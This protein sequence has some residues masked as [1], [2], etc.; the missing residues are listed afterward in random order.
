[1]VYP[2]IFNGKSMRL[3]FLCS[4]LGNWCIVSLIAFGFSSP[5][6]RLIGSIAVIIEKLFT[7]FNMLLG[8]NAYSV[9]SCH[10][11]YLYKPAKDKLFPLF[12]FW[13][14][15]AR[16]TI[17]F[18]F[19]GRFLKLVLPLHNSWGWTNDSRTLACLLYDMHQ[20]HT[21]EIES[22]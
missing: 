20:E 10:Q 19:H 5:R 22:C 18:R 14:K 13:D 15:L 8:K 7:S 2:N 9:I 6:R 1:M 3:M 11:H 12:W 17:N 4:P 21:V 16:I